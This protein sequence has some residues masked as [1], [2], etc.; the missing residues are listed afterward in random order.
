M[1]PF[2]VQSDAAFATRLR[3]H[4]FAGFVKILQRSIPRD[5]G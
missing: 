3:K 1:R 5:E 4:Y 2:T